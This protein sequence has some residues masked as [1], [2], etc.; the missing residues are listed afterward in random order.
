MQVNAGAVDEPPG[1]VWPDNVYADIC[2]MTF[3]Y[4]EEW[5]KLH[6]V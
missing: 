3:A 6:A 2:E 1:Y 5:E 4:D